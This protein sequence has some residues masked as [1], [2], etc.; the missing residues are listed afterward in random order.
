LIKQLREARLG[1]ADAC[2]HVPS[3]VTRDYVG[4]RRQAPRAGA[5]S[6]VGAPFRGDPATAFPSGPTTPYARYE[7]WTPGWRIRHLSASR[8]TRRHEVAMP[9]QAP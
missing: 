5:A 9:G 8:L 6:G 1:G 3:V 4:K 2:V 7:I